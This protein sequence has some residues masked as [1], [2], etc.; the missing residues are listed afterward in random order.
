[1]KFSADTNADALEAW[2]VFAY[3]P[4]SNIGGQT[5]RLHLENTNDIT[6]NTNFFIDSLRL[7]ATVCQ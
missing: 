1:M 7:S 4:I 6:N 5:I 3:A 2:T